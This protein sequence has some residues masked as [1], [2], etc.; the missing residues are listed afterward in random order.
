MNNRFKKIIAAEFAVAISRCAANSIGGNDVNLKNVQA[1]LDMLG[2]IM[3][4]IDS[5][6]RSPTN[7]LQFAQWYCA[8]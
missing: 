3:E 5:G 8:E 6:A 7:A 4:D 1:Y 2:F